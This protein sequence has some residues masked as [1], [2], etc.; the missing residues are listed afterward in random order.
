MTTVELPGWAPQC[1]G[2]VEEEYVI[3]YCG[4]AEKR[5]GHLI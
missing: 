4:P 3:P 1:G 5:S 2:G